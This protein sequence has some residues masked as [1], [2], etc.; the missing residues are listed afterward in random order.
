MQQTNRFADT[1]GETTSSYANL[2]RRNFLTKLFGATAVTAVAASCTKSLT[3]SGAANASLLGNNANGI[4]NGTISMGSGDYAI[5]NYAYLLEQLEAQ[6]YTMAT[7]NYFNNATPQQKMR[8]AQI[9]D[10]EIAHREFFKS[11]LGSYAIPEIMFD[12]SSIDFSSRYSVLSTA[13]TFEDLGVS[14]YNGVAQYIV[15]PDYLVV[16]GKIVSVEARH[17]AYVRDLLRPVSFADPLVV[18]NMGLDK[19]ASPKEVIP[20]LIPFLPVTL[21]TSKA[22][23]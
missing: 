21:D 6:F 12:L 8:L 20:N 22:P 13:R 14:A 7:A 9:R 4:A 2:P 23:W 17:A 10:H 16:A 5:L 18:D 1:E 19:A 15:T 11:A 3:D